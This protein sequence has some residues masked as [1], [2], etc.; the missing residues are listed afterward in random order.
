MTCIITPSQLTPLTTPAAVR[1]FEST[2]QRYPYL[3][4]PAPQQSGSQAAGQQNQPDP[5]RIPQNDGQSDLDSTVASGSGSRLV[6]QTAFGSINGPPRR[7]DLDQELERRLRGDLIEIENIEVEG[8]IVQV[9]G[10]DD[11]VF[12]HFSG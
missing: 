3:Q 7:S 11:E 2:W 10:E 12:S 9:D 1:P 4:A 5:G 6:S 8:Q